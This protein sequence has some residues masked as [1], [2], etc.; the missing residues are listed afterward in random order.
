MNGYLDLSVL[1]IMGMIRSNEISELLA[2]GRLPPEYD[3]KDK[4]LLDNV[5]YETRP[6]WEWNI[7]P[8]SIEVI[9]SYVRKNKNIKISLFSED[10]AALFSLTTD[11]VLMWQLKNGIESNRLV[12]NGYPLSHPYYELSTGAVPLLSYTW[13]FDQRKNWIKKIKMRTKL[14]EAEA[15]LTGFGGDFDHDF[16]QWLETNFDMKIKTWEYDDFER[17]GSPSHYISNF[18]AQ[19]YRINRTK[20]FTPLTLEEINSCIKD[21]SKYYPGAYFNNKT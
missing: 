9:K 2:L 12:F 14:T 7:E 13:S 15:Y 6:Q 3:K 17:Q 20:T 19:Q 8:E 4:I 1:K 21:F 10:D 11:L 18:I 5:K 16:G